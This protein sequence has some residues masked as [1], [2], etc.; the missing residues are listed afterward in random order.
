MRH[1]GNREQEV[2]CLASSSVMR[3]SA[4]LICSETC[5]ISAI[6][7][8]AL[9]FSFSGARFHRWPCPLCLAMLV[10]CDQ[11]A[12]ILVERAKPLQIQRDVS[13]LRHC[14]KNVEVLS[15]WLKSCMIAWFA[16]RISSAFEQTE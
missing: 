1:I 9:C 16:L 12:A 2:R 11:F 13:P 3:S 7:A 10:R 6:S 8:S 4:C 15:K 5:F 14:G